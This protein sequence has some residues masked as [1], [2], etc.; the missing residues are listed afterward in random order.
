MLSNNN[1]LSLGG[2]GRQ[3]ARR[4]VRVDEPAHG[5]FVAGSS[6]EGMNGVYVRRNPPRTKLTPDQLPIALYYE[7]EEGAYHMVLS[8][9]VYTE[10]E[11]ES[12]DEDDYRY[13]YNYRPKKKRPTHIWSFRDEFH[14]D[15]FTHEG[16]TIVP[17]AGTRWSHYHMK[18][19]APGSNA[20]NSMAEDMDTDEPIAAA[21]DAEPES[22]STAAETDDAATTAEE[23]AAKAKA[24]QLAE[25]KEDDEDELP[26]QVIAILDVDMVQQ[27][28][29]SSEHRKRK[30]REAKAGRNAPQPARASLEGAFAPGRWLFRVTPAAVDGVVLRTAPDDSAEAA[31]TRT[32]G[33]FLRA[34]KVGVGGEW[35]CLDVCEDLSAG[36]AR[37]FSSRYY[38]ADHARRELWVRRTAVDNGSSFFAGTDSGVAAGTVLLEEVHANDTAVLDLSAVGDPVGCEGDGD[39]STTATH[40][41]GMTG[42]FMDKP[43]VPRMEDASSSSEAEA[44][45][46]ASEHG[47]V[48]GLVAD[49]QEDPALLVVHA[50]RAKALVRGGFPVGTAVEICGLQS[51]AAQQYNGVTGVVV[52][53][54]KAESG[55]QGV[56]LDAPF[57]GKMIACTPDALMYCGEEDGDESEEEDEDD[58]VKDEGYTVS[59][60]ARLLGLNLEQLGLKGAKPTTAAAASAECEDNEISNCNCDGGWGFFGTSPEDRVGAAVR[61]AI[62]DAGLD[63]YAR[64]AARE[65]AECLFTALSKL[66]EQK[67]VTPATSAATTT[68]ARSPELMLRC[69]ALGTRIAA[70]AVSA[71][72][73]TSATERDA[74]LQHLRA[75][76]KEETSRARAADASIMVNPGE[77]SGGADELL[78]RLAL[79][80]AL[81]ENRCE[82]EALE[83]ARRAASFYESRCAPAGAG[84]SSH[85]AVSLLLGRCLLRQG[86]RADGLTEL[87]K[88]ESCASLHNTPGG[89]EPLLRPLWEFGKS[90]A[91][92]LLVAHRAAERCRVAGVESYG[93][94]NF[95]EA[96]GLYRRSLALLKAGCPDD[97]R[98]RATALA[99]RAGCLR[100]ARQLDEAVL[101]LDEALHLF[102]RY[103]RALFRRAACL[104]EAGQATAAKEGFKA[105]YRVDRDWPDLSLWLIRAFSLEKRQARG[106]RRDDGEDDD[107]DNGAGSRSPTPSATPDSDKIAKEVCHYTVLGVTTDATEKQLKTAYRMRSLQFHP[108][109]KQ[110]TTAAFQRIAEAYQVLCEPDKRQA[111]DEGRDIKV[112]KGR[113]DE[114]DDSEDSEEDEEHKTTM[115]E[116]VEREFYPER[117]HFWPF[118]DPFIYK[119]KREAQKRAEREAREG[120]Q[121]N[122]GEDDY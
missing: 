38:R 62:R 117:Y 8:E 120:N 22:E 82:A 41:N 23:E 80:Q 50:E 94:G 77:V 81:M 79:V 40:V 108:D 29:Y 48:L 53:R 64:D 83:E 13:Y 32:A 15:R 112:K 24:S 109:R 65:A 96:A 42:D 37:N 3:R 106:Y 102:P 6:L 25:I 2:G 91:T 55:K 54:V 84:P 97:K 85:P 104:L 19:P 49:G 86:L 9:L 66:K 56:R 1:Q 21:P 103:S 89:A 111:Y 59:R 52:T 58:D 33:E 47:L 7:H 87:E 115:R 116:E 105:L 31:G 18:P 51:R 98:G 119:R 36:S 35:I 107:E 71:M 67:E 78:L 57:S 39:A 121:R 4:T 44:A 68:E 74:G 14:K 95:P 88:A 17:G 72:S 101:D 30:V 93:R 43:F 90:E 99:D 122:M 46:A 114:E 118:G 45:E 76:L 16:D 70:A 11:E 20:S 63:S 10:P 100:R 60:S 73:N 75:A 92:R 12:D 34:V 27:L 110:G 113:R 26:W 28:L 69:G 61:S 5:F